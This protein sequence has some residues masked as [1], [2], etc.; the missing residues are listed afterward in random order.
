V[1][2]NQVGVLTNM[3]DDGKQLESS[4]GREVVVGQLG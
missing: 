1:D 4:D 3:E 2:G